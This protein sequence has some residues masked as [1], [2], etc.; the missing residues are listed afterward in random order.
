MEMGDWQATPHAVWAAAF[1][2]TCS[3]FPVL[4]SEHFVGAVY[5]FFVLKYRR[6]LVS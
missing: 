5:A 3:I 4:L 1:L 6:D 2:C